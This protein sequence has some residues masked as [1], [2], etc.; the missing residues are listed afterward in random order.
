M[1]VKSRFELR[2]EG[3]LR[4]TA[5]KIA[6]E[7]SQAHARVNQFYDKTRP[8]AFHLEAVARNTARYADEVLPA[9]APDELILALWFGAWFHDSIEDA[10]MTYNDVMK[11]ASRYLEPEN[12]LLATEIVY[13]LTNEKGRTRAERADERYYALIRRTPYAP[14][15]KVADRIA[16]IEYSVSNGQCGMAKMYAGELPHFI[17]S[18]QGGVTEVPTV[19]VDRLKNLCL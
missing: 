8:Y 10:R 5:A 12:A 4:D 9:D 3:P 16:N 2:L 13:A 6:E 17:Q 15:V 18:V 14:L 1:E 7:A 19:M 11:V